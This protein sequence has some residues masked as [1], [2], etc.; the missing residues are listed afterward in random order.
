MKYKIFI[1]AAAVLTMA[2][3]VNKAEIPADIIVKLESLGGS[4][5]RF[6]VAVTNRDA[7]Y[8]YVQISEDMEI[9][10][11]PAEDAVKEE[12]ARM[13]FIYNEAIENGYWEK[14]DPDFID[15]FFYRGSRQFSM[16]TMQDDT[17]FRFIVFQIN[18]KTHEIIGEP[19]SISYHTLPVP[20][21]DLTFDISFEADVVTI[22]PSDDNLTYFW[23]YE[24]AKII[25]NAYCIPYLYAYQLVSMYEEYGFMESELSKGRDTW[26]FTLQDKTMTEGE[27]CIMIIAGCEDAE[28]TTDIRA[29]QFRYSKEKGIEVLNWNYNAYF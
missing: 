28:F 27:E 1:A 11:L 2:S 5:A 18:P 22:V 4:R 17:D 10:N 24:D 20:K 3:C 29:I 6:S 14:E 9:F 16:T 12:I 13:E 15:F 7:V 25:Q 23:D 8:S 19:Q 21:R 26:N